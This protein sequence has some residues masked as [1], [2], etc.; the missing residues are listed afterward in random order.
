[1]VFIALAAAAAAYT[2]S[3]IS[4]YFQTSGIPDDGVRGAV[5]DSG[6][7]KPTG[8]GTFDVI[9]RAHAG[10]PLAATENS[11]VSCTRNACWT[12]TSFSVY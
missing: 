10:T 5:L 6:S 12:S 1:M 7:N 11:S 8:N 2:A 9:F 3:S 4:L